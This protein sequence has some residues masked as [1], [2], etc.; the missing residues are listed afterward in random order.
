[1]HRLSGI[2]KIDYI[3]LMHFSFTVL[4]KTD[5]SFL[6]LHHIKYVTLKLKYREKI[7]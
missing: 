1:M 6:I 4:G 5:P 3:K 2:I 7:I